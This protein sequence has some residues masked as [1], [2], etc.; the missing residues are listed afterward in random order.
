MME[1]KSLRMSSLITPSHIL[2]VFVC[3]RQPGRRV[4]CCVV[5]ISFNEKPKLH[6]DRL[7][8]QTRLSLL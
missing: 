8:E 6:S 1:P 7:A 2:F 5:Q 4:L 3:L